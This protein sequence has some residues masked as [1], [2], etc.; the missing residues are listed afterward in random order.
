MLRVMSKGRA[1]GMLVAAAL[2][3]LLLAAC[4]GGGSSKTS[5][6]ANS[7][8]GALDAANMVP[9]TA[10]AYASITVKPGASLGSDLKQTIDKLAGPGAANHLVTSFESQL[11]TA[12]QVSAVKAWLGPQVGIALTTLPSGTP[13]S[14]TLE[15]HLLIVAPTTNPAAATKFLQKQPKSSFAFDSKTGGTYKVVG[16]FVLI[17]GKAAIQ[18]AASTTSANSLA[19]D[20]SFKSVMSQ[21]GDNQLAAVFARPKPI[22]QALAPTLSA[23]PSYAQL[24]AAMKKIPADSALAF[25]LTAGSKTLSFDVVTQGFPK[26]SSHGASSDVASLPGTS[27]LALAIAGSLGN[28]KTISTLQK[29][30]PSLIAAGQSQAGSAGS[31]VQGFLPFVQ[32]DVVPALGPISLSIAGTSLASLRVGFEMTPTD[33]AAGGK[34]VSSLKK[35]LTGLPLDVN[36]VGKSVVL[37]F[38]YAS[39]QDFLSPPSHLSDSPTYKAALAQ[40]PAGGQTPIY[41]S[42]GPIAALGAA[43]DKNKSDASVWKIAGKLN[44]LIAGG[45]STHIRVVLGVK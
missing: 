44:Y 29:E 25:G 23:S 45:T 28:P 4:G 41:V 5:T 40:M 22:L 27:W 3:A 6:N 35:M 19:S 30:L 12:A 24:G 42:F 11:G 13:T 16:H 34:L 15:Q 31:S 37:T 43:L 36:H 14:A 1:L 8:I 38:G 20:A 10:V 7:G 39:A 17:G 33:S 18:A 32:N 26:S 21:I 9:A 2:V